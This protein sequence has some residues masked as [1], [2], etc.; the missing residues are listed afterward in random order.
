MARYTLQTSGRLVLVGPDGPCGV[1]DPI[2][3]PLLVLAALHA[4]GGVDDDAALL[5]LTPDLTPAAGRARL[6][7]AAAAVAASAGAPLIE[8]SDGRLTPRRDLVGVDVETSAVAE[9]HP[10]QAGFL[11]GVLLP[12]PEFGDWVADVR[13]RIRAA[14]GPARSGSWLGTPTD[15]TAAL[16]AL[17]GLILLV[18]VWATRAAPPPG[19]AAGAAIVLADLDNATG[20]TLFDQSLIV[21]AAVGLGQSARFSILSRNRV[22]EALQRMGQSRTDTVRL[23]FELAREVAA[24]ENTQYVLGFRIERVGEGY[25]LYSTLAEAGSGQAVR[26]AEASAETRAGTLSALDRLID[27]TRAG[28]GESR[29]ERRERSVGL[30]AA[31]TPSVEALRSYAQGSLAWGRGEFAIAKELWGRA[32]DVDTGFAMALGAMGAYYTRHHDRA[33]ATRF[34]TQALRQ[35]DR[36]TEL[37]RL[38]LE[39][40]YAGL[41]G[42]TDSMLAIDRAIVARFPSAESWYGYGTELM[43]LGRSR[44]ALNALTEAL[45][46]DSTDANIHGNLGNAAKQTD[47]LDLALEHFKR[48]DAIDSTV[49]LRGFVI[50]EY[51]ELLV[52]LGRFDEADDHFRRILSRPGIRDRPYALRSLGLLRVWRGRLDEAVGF[53]RQA[54]AASIQ[55]DD[56]TALGALRGRAYEGLTLLLMGDAQE[57]NRALDS[58]MTSIRPN[59]EPQALALFVRTLLR[60]NR[61]A[62]AR[63]LAALPHD[64]VGQAD[65][66]ALR[67]VSAAVAIAGGQA[68]SG[69]ALLEAGAAAPQP[70]VTNWLRVEGLVGQRKAEPAL[71]LADSLT[72]SREFGTESQFEWIWGLVRAADLAAE[73]GHGKAALAGYRR[74]IDLWS[75]G[76]R[77]SALLDHARKQVEVLGT[78]R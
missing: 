25:R 14:H 48:A 52:R 76:D 15:R 24:R 67:F 47:Q 18:S 30:P 43:R 19:L 77:S 17:G 46:F 34:Y 4:G 55:V 41:R 65:R 7:A 66:K 42:E 21:A 59:V 32:L 6:A 26:S 33:A 3:L 62:D 71:A 40:G 53:L 61:I 56:R 23:S 13:P 51:G 22:V 64:T 12:S 1:D 39:E 57:A 27:A 5:L 8:Y 75:G 69:M 68:D 28:L 44:E 38:R 45:R 58:L 20:D 74:L 10:L 50:A 54:T 11:A 37:E 31:T 36:L 70:A 73:L 29:S 35:R 60:A 49:L 9:H 63:R 16:I 2:A 72:A 78:A